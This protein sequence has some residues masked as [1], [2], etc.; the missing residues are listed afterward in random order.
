MMDR[1]TATREQTEFTGA[2]GNRLVADMWLPVAGQDRMRAPLLFL[3][4]GGQTRHAWGRTAQDMARKGAVTISLDQRGHGDSEWVADWGYSFRHYGEDALAVGR[5]AKERFG[6]A[7]IAIGASLGGIASML[8]EGEGGPG[9]WSALVLV[10]ITPKMDPA[11]VDRIQS[12][13]GADLERGFTSIEA[14]AEAVAAYLPH[15]PRPR[16]L[17]GLRKNLRQGADGRYRWHWDPRFLVGPCSVNTDRDQAE[18]EMTAAIRNTPI[19][20]LLV[21]GGS[22]EL[23]SPEHAEAFVELV[24]HA[25]TVDV[26]GAGHMVA[27]DRNDIFSAAIGEFLEKT[28]G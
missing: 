4:G 22:S 24:P 5:Q 23:I 17:E 14:A 27:G 15:R 9:F 16:S 28:T 11:G 26:G 19:P 10:D 3:H 8:A 25:Q 13:M 2:Q 7:P 18:A 20:V 12:F 1:D 6:V 21:R